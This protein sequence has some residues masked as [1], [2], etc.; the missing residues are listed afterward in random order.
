LQTQNLVM[1]LAR[2]FASRLATPTA[3]FDPEGAILYFNEAAESVLGQRYVEGER[4]SQATLLATLRPVDEQG[5][6]LPPDRRPLRIVLSARTPAHGSMHVTGRDG[7]ERSIE[8][9][10]FPLFARADEFVGAIAIFWEHEDG[11]GA[12]S[13]SAG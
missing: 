4:I 11:A 2:D 13:Q 9:T 7:V 8:V 6:P 3:L 1:I 5:E 10:A 12:A